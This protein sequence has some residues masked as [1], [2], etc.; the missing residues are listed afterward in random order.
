LDDL[1]RLPV[2]QNIEVSV[3]SPPS[4]SLD[5]P[6]SKSII[7]GHTLWRYCMEQAHHCDDPENL[8]DIARTRNEDCL[9]PLDGSMM[10]KW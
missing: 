5:L 1:D 8:L 2:M 7:P 6:Q 10:R 9:S 3:P 4:I